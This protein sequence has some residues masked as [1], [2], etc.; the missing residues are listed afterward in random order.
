MLRGLAAFGEQLMHQRGSRL[1]ILPGA[2]LGS[3][4]AALL[5]GD[6]QFVVFDAEHDLVSNFDAEGFAK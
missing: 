1:Q 2:L 4:N 5:G 6:A 3:L